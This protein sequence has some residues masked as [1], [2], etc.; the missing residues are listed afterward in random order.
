MPHVPAPAPD[1]LKFHCYAPTKRTKKVA[2]RGKRHNLLRKMSDTLPDTT[3]KTEQNSLST[4]PQ[5]KHSTNR[6][7]V[8]KGHHP[9]DQNN[10]EPHSKSIS[11]SKR[12]PEQSSIHG[13]GDTGIRSRCH[14][15]R[16]MMTVRA[17]SALADEGGFVRAA[18]AKKRKARST[19]NL[20]KESTNAKDIDTSSPPRAAQQKGRKMMKKST[21]TSEEEAQDQPEKEE[22]RF[23]TILPTTTDENTRQ[24]HKQ[25]D[26]AVKGSSSDTITNALDCNQGFYGPSREDAALGCFPKQP[27]EALYHK[28]ETKLTCDEEIKEIVEYA[29][30]V[31][32]SVL[33]SRTFLTFMR[34][35]RANDPVIEDNPRTGPK[36]ES[37]HSSA[38]PSATPPNA[39]ACESVACIDDTV[40]PTGVATKVSDE[41][42]AN[43]VLYFSLAVQRFAVEVYY[44]YLVASKKTMG[45]ESP[46]CDR[47]LLSTFLALREML[48][49]NADQVFNSQDLMRT[50]GMQPPG[51]VPGCHLEGKASNRITGIDS[52]SF[53]A[54][55]IAS[56]IIRLA[57][58]EVSHQQGGSKFYQDFIAVANNYD[59]HSDDFRFCLR[60]ADARSSCVL[61][62]GRTL[63][64]EESKIAKTSF[65]LTRNYHPLIYNEQQEQ[66]I[67]L[68]L[69]EDSVEVVDKVE[70]KNKL[71]LPRANACAIFV[72]AETP[73]QIQPQTNDS[74]LELV[75][76]QNEALDSYNK[77]KEAQ[78]ER[79][80]ENLRKIKRNKVSC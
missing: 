44:P 14:Q 68:S 70:A 60:H 28:P 29:S 23:D 30:N 25:V 69:N 18:S 1:L 54:R 15:K 80:R 58:Q 71:V 33:R 20:E 77:L 6:A 37:S 72:M 24:L 39:F 9:H 43:S 36:T 13:T 40:K 51:K 73:T 31:V 46:R 10:E 53:I 75:G 42:S 66:E 22:C 5:D 63:G 52:F 64:E 41:D 19:W 62:N 38:F 17:A 78:R 2:K 56:M 35:Q 67:S 21:D 74:D 3:Q 49:T 16:H 55:N 59:T 7:S 8:E 76:N 32:A 12:I 47:V 79:R 11:N 50:A 57:A 48:I 27:P 34:N 4:I 45:N 26:P 65:N 61:P